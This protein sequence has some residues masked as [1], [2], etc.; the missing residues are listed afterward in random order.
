MSQLPSLGPRGEGWVAVQVVLLG[1]RRVD[2]GARP[3]RG[4]ASAARQLR[5]RPGRDRGRPGLSGL[6]VRHS[7]RATRSLPCPTPGTTR[8]SS[9]PVPTRPVRHPIYAGLIGG[10][11]GWGLVAASPATL[12][13]AGALFAFFELK[14][15]REEAWLERRF[16]EYAAYRARTPRLIPWIGGGRG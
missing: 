15:R 6:G 11:I 1:A 10:A 3:G 16:P 7:P 13:P 9:R 5:G 12:A 4:R 2:G 8:G 14:S